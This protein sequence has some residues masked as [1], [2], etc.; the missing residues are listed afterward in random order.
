MRNNN[1]E[2]RHGG[3]SLPHPFCTSCDKKLCGFI[4]PHTRLQISSPWIPRRGAEATL[5]LNSSCWTT[6][7]SVFTNFSSGFTRDLNIS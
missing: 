5:I 6:V 1:V 7:V 4:C 3:L 2:I